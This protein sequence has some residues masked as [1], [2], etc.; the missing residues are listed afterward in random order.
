MLLG[1][2][3]GVRTVRSQAR[4]LAWEEGRG[5]CHSLEWETLK[6]DP[7]VLGER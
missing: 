7:I 3:M 2:D 4:F 5:G 6:V 1:L